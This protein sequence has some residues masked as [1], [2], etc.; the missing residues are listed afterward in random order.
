MV[1]RKILKRTGNGGSVGSQGPTRAGAL[2]NGFKKPWGQSLRPKEIKREL[3]KIGRSD[4]K[5]WWRV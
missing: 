4:V 5:P 2:R 1:K 3:R